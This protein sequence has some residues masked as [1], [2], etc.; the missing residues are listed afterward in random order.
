MCHSINNTKGCQMGPTVYSPYLRRLKV[1]PLED[2][3][4]KGN[5]FSSDILGASV[6]VQLGIQT[7]DL[8]H[9]SLMLGAITYYIRVSVC[10]RVIFSLGLGLLPFLASLTR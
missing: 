7:H 4:N 1:S 8:P 2:A 5:D 3:I 9:D 10:V 6:F